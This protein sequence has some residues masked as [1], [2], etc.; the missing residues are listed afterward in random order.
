[1]FSSVQRYRIIPNYTSSDK[2]RLTEPD[3]VKNTKKTEVHSAC[4][5]NS[6]EEMRQGTETGALQAPV[7]RGTEK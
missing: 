2:K 7:F 1:M 5:Q 3:H 4:Y 6:K